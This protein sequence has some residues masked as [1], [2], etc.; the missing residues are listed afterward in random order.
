MVDRH[1]D[2]KKG[3][4]ENTIDRLRSLQKGDDPLKRLSEIAETGKLFRNLQQHG[5]DIYSALYDT[6]VALHRKVLSG[7][8]NPEQ[9]EIL[10]KEAEKF[11][12]KALKL[13]HLMKK[14][15]EIL[16]QKDPSHQDKSRI[17]GEF[18]EIEEIKHPYQYKKNVEFEIRDRV[19]TAIRVH[20]N[21]VSMQTELST[22]QRVTF[23]ETRGNGWILIRL[24]DGKGYGFTHEFALKGTPEG[25]DV[26]NLSRFEPVVV[27][28]PS[29]SKYPEITAYESNNTDKSS[30]DIPDFTV[31]PYVKGIKV[32][33][34]VL[35]YL[36]DNQEV[37]IREDGIRSYDASSS[38]RENIENISDSRIGIVNKPIISFYR[39]R[40]SNEA[41]GN[42]YISTKLSLLKDYDY[43]EEQGRLP[44]ISPKGERVW[45]K[46][47]DIHLRNKAN[48][49]PRQPIEE[50]VKL[51]QALQDQDTPYR[52]G[53]ATP[54]GYDCSKFVET[55]YRSAGLELPLNSRDQYRFT[56][57]SGDF[58][59]V[60]VYA[61]P[62]AIGLPQKFA[63]P[64][65]SEVSLEKP[66]AGDLVFFRYP[67]TDKDGEIRTDENGKIKCAP[68]TYDGIMINDE[69]FIHAEGNKHEK[70][71]KSRLACFHDEASDK[72]ERYTTKAH[73]FEIMRP[74]W[75]Y[76]EDSKG[77]IPETESSLAGIDR[78]FTETTKFFDNLFSRT[79]DNEILRDISPR[80]KERYM[81]L[82][83][84]TELSKKV[85]NDSERVSEIES[86]TEHTSTEE[87]MNVFRTCTESLMEIKLQLEEY[88]Q[89]YKIE[90]ERKM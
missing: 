60:A 22:S 49:F 62:D 69:E 36:P 15:Q 29:G 85:I 38:K 70:V 55:C 87:A 66:R 13:N 16:N 28:S 6:S 72:A 37:W 67:E 61:N 57:E 26:S 39:D 82:K 63:E 43:T 33:G 53:G 75:Y 8:Y 58:R 14:N 76:N 51:A 46:S 4:I 12:T 1:S 48:P 86:I 19:V 41:S 21:E 88:M 74:L 90:K 31:L 24:P 17:L 40:E 5:L 47:E 7:Q 65:R 89:K 35:V 30:G 84:G 80:V 2:R 77:E 59:C 56:Q 18:R 83:A 9:Q 71:I 10:Q 52:W 27:A 79:Q 45:V 78:Y 11:F 25:G 32:N 23:K 20:N 68:T 34:R 54:K 44:V 50:V 73:Q 42:F 81:D 3:F 64:L